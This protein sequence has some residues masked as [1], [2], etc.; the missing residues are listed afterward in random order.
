MYVRLSPSIP[1]RAT[2]GP[3]ANKSSLGSATFDNP[4]GVVHWFIRSLSPIR[5]GSIFSSPF[6]CDHIYIYKELFASANTQYSERKRIPFLSTLLPA[7]FSE[8]LNV[9]FFHFCVLLLGARTP[10][11]NEP[12][13]KNEE[14]EEEADGGRKK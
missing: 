12:M 11:N 8:N 1:S 14:E 13:R 7:M 4:H 6:R 5:T 10:V 2:H 9:S 3:A